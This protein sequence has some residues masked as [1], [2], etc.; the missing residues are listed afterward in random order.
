MLYLYVVLHGN[1]SNVATTRPNPTF[2]PSIPTNGTF[3]GNLVKLQ[4]NSNG[5][6]SGVNDWQTSGYGTMLTTF[7]STTI[8]L[9]LSEFGCNTD[10]PRSFDEVSQGVY[11]GLE[12]SFSGGLV[13]EYSQEVSN[14]GLVQIQSS[15]DIQLRQDFV[16]LKNQYQQAVPKLANTSESDISTVSPQACSAS[17]ITALYSGF[18]TDMDLPACPAPDMLK[19]GGGN[20]N[21][22]KIVTVNSTQSSYKFYDVS[23]NEINLSLNVAPSNLINSLNGS[24]SGAETSSSSS[25]ATSSSSSHKKNDA[26]G[27]AAPGGLLAAV[28]SLI[29]ALL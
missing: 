24:S 27:V 11:A 23:G 13:Y 14:Y 9:F 26:A 10:S 17:A 16:N 19:N 18:E 6:C 15:G 20:K 3:V 12:Q 21:I 8:P 22:G 2:T 4:S 28:F 5:R 25:S 7:N 29:F 1:T